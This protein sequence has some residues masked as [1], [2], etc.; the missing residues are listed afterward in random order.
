MR[1]EIVIEIKTQSYYKWLIDDVVDIFEEYDFPCWKRDDENLRFYFSDVKTAINIEG[2]HLFIELVASP[3]E[4]LIIPILL[5]QI[6][7]FSYDRVIGKRI[8]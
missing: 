2:K 5:N 1:E 7:Y 8:H 6:Q 3:K 4:K